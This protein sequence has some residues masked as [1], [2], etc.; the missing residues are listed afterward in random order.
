MD[1]DSAR[2]STGIRR[3]TAPQR[4][5]DPR[6]YA[7]VS[8][9]L[10]LCSARLSE[11]RHLTARECA[12]GVLELAAVHFGVLGNTVLESWGVHTSEDIGLIVRALIDRGVVSPGEEDDLEDFAGLFSVDE[13]YVARYQIWEG[14]RS[15]SAKP[16][17]RPGS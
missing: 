13:D 16:P 6:A 2:H 12:D 1:D 9:T 4:L 10:S 8:E 14:L 11:P 5:Y 7:F 3:R 15:R 17:G